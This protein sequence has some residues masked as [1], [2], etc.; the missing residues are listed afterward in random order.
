MFPFLKLIGGIFLKIKGKGYVVLVLLFL[1]LIGIIYNQYNQIGFLNKRVS[2][3]EKRLGGPDKIL[4][5]EKDTIEKVRQSVVRI[6]GGEAEGSGFAIKSGGLILT[7]FHVIEFEPSPKVIFPDNT[8]ETA[9]ILMAD[10]NA[11]L[12]ILKIH[13]EL[14]VIS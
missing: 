12:A 8:F 3:V 13:R 1:A 2:L 5:N 6:V 10:R 4:C 9:E 14:P 7:N 11:D